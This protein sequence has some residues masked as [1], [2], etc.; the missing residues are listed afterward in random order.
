MQC[1]YDANPMSIKSQ[2]S[3]N[4]VP[5][6]VTGRQLRKEKG[7]KFTVWTGYWSRRR[8]NRTPILNQKKCKY[9]NPM[10]ILQSHVN[11]LPISQSHFCRLPP[12]PIAKRPCHSFTGAN[13]QNWIDTHWHGHVNHASQEDNSVRGRGT[14]VLQGSTTGLVGG[15]FRTSTPILDLSVK[16][17]HVPIDYQFDINWEPIQF[18][19]I[20]A[21]HHDVSIQCQ[22]GSNFAIQCQSRTNFPIYW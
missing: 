18:R 3:V 7:N 8:T 10:S 11:P 20:P 17:N 14:S 22:S 5:I 12:S 15:R 9:D 16:S 2:S 1:R 19:S 6:G 13:H 21:Q 4:Q